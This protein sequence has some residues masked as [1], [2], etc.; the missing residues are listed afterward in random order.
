MIEIRNRILQLRGEVAQHQ[1]AYHQEDAPLISDAQ[2]DAL[3]RE[4]ETLESQYPDLVPGPSP[5][6]QVGFAPK[7]EFSEVVH[8]VP[9]LSLNNAFE[10]TD[11]EQFVARLAKDLALSAAD[12]RFS[13]ELKFDG[14]AVSLR[15]ERGKLVQ[16]ATR[17]DGSVGEDITPNLLVVKGVP[18]RLR[19]SNIPDVLEVRG[20]VLMQKADFAALN[21][22][23]AA[24]GDKVFV[25]PRNAAAGSLRQLDPNITA[26]RPL[27][28]FAYGTGE[29]VDHAG[30]TEHLDTHSAWLAWLAEL[31]LPVGQ[32]RGKNLD[33]AGLLQFYER[34]LSKRAA[35]PF[36]ID[37]VVY[38]LESIALQ[39]R[40]G[41]VSRAPRFAL[42]HKFPAE[43]AS[44]ILLDIDVQVGRTGALTPVARLEPVFVGGVTVTN[45]TL[46]NEDEIA[47]KNLMLGDTVWV[48]RAGDV[49]PE[50]LGPVLSLRPT[51]ARLFKMPS[52]CPVCGSLAVREA[53]EAVSR[54]PA[55]LSCKAQRKQAFLHFAQRRAMDIE[56]LGEKIVDQLVDQSLVTT[57]ADLYRLD[58]PTLAGLERMADK[59]AQNL[60]DQ[61]NRS[62]QASLARFLFGLGVRHVGERTARDLALHFQSI[63]EIRNASIEQLMAAPDVGPV[64]AQSI[65][66]FFDHPQQ[67]VV[68]D[69]LLQEI[70][71][72]R[73]DDR[74]AVAPTR[75]TNSGAAGAGAEASALPLA[76]MTV[77]LTGTLSEMTRDEA[78]DWVLALGG[79]TS[80][81]VSA[82]TSLVVAG[83]A[84]G[85][86]LE[87]ANALGVR[88]ID[89]AAFL[90]M[91]APY[92]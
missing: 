59:S 31:G 22:Q 72:D 44:T 47:R 29:V 12:L 61:I 10:T 64:V 89:E 13:A 36:E 11:V 8:R 17:G 24:A 79:K 51:N 83:E 49:I 69:Q 57:L 58:L 68:V 77:V 55:G 53:G 14:I 75:S 56:G 6:D 43:E 7:R 30:L 37:G 4:L 91:I 3:V 35:L 26:R 41:F 45:A 54:C 5:V 1:R 39:T 48:R 86:K 81:S 60:I 2:Y 84:A 85:S 19:G 80:G 66:T 42:A 18:H 82:K 70:T 27:T 76:G 87:K 38:K 33:G 92:R 90:A 9:M 88:V 74:P 63:D 46:H 40:A 25:N 67:S 28:F 65:R 32:E 20:E 34:I 73:L 52:H 71:I 62:R 23:Q 21:A 15:Y 16:A 78:G 50:V